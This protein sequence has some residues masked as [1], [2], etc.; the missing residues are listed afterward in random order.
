M[1]LSSFREVTDDE[2]RKIVLSSKTTSCALDPIPTKL[3]KECLDFLLPVITKIA[4]ASLQSGVF[5]SEWKS[6]LVV[7]LLKK[8]G[9]DLTLNNYRPVSNLQ[10]I[11]KVVE[12]TVI[13]QLFTHM[14]EHCPLP[15]N[16]SAYRP[17]H[18]TET[19]L[20]KIQSDI[21]T[22]ME[23]QKV[24]ILVLIDL[25]AA[26][27]TIDTDILCSILSTKFRVKNTAL[28]WFKSYLSSRKLQVS[29]NGTLSKSFNLPFGVPQGSCLGPIL[30]T[31][32]CQ[33]NTR[34]SRYGH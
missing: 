5:P 15:P 32:I 17:M 3:L 1:V 2:I 20:V 27:D 30:F 24:T 26:F 10:F 18:S 7:P 16:Q 34:S 25:S 33:H 13:S 12:R 4:N 11:S 6:A 23:H 28:E 31:I 14:N 9:L 29:V 8:P 21:L 19:I 22:N